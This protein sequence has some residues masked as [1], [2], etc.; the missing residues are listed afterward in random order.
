MD[1]Y[2]VTGNPVEHSQSP[3]IHAEFARQTGQVLDYGR[4]LCPARRVCGH[5]AAVCGRCHR[6][7]GARLQRHR[8]VQ[9][10]GLCARAPTHSACHAGPGLQHAALRFRRLARRQHRR[11]PASWPTSR[12]N[13]GVPM[14]GRRLLLIGAGGAAAG[15]PSGPLLAA[16]PAELGG[17][18][19]HG[20][21]GASPGG[22]PRQGG[23]SHAPARSDT[24]RLRQ[25]LRR[26]RQRHR[27]QLGRRSATGGRRGARPRR[28]GARHDV[29]PCRAGLSRPGPARTARVGATAWGCWSSR[30]PRPSCC[31][32]ACGPTPPPCWPRCA[33]GW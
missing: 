3:F 32:G 7:R 11:A 15:G 10:R 18:Q 9:V 12:R 29:R 33:H 25:P 21:Q 20:R 30:L 2:V 19:P 28:T 22:A 23:R 24:G 5:G 1:R 31:G 6:R 17:G 13:A 16:E 14:R 4:L 27:Q 26:G 8:A